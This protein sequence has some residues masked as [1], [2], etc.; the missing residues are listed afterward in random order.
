MQATKVN[1]NKR[2]IILLLLVLALLSACRYNPSYNEVLEEELASNVR[3]DSIIYGV[4][5]G[6]TYDD[7][8]FYCWNQHL[9]GVFMPG[10]F[11]DAVK[12]EIT[13]EVH[14]PLIV[15]FFPAD[16]NDKFEPIKKYRVSVAFKNYSQ[17]NKATSMENLVKETMRF[18]EDGYGGRK[19]IPVPNTTN[20]L[21]KN[22]F[23]KVDGNRK[24]T[25]YPEFKGHKLEIIFEDLKPMDDDKS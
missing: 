3:H 5:L 14:S 2:S 4:K 24:I 6:M 15:E 17:Y 13:E 10:G 12:V 8:H 16:V 21:I 19:F 23:I 7:F 11:G 9:E 1:M 25:L 18:F 20:V 22:N